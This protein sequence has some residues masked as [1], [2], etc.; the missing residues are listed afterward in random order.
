MYLVEAGG[1]TRMQV[2]KELYAET[3]EQCFELTWVCE[4]LAS[5]CR[6]AGMHSK[7]FSCGCAKLSTSVISERIDAEDRQ[8]YRR[9]PSTGISGW[10][11]SRESVKS[12]NSLVFA[13]QQYI[14]SSRKEAFRNL[15]ELGKEPCGGILMTLMLGVMRSGANVRI[16]SSELGRLR[17]HFAK[18]R[19]PISTWNSAMRR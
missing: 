16:F 10:A 19:R 14:D 6:T 7:R 1:N 12:A 5:C 15:L 17:L 18:G 3:G 4:Q 8:P 11:P 13:G 2:L 9:K